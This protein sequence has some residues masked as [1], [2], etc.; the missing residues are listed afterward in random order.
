MTDFNFSSLSCRNK[1]R[2]GSG[3]SLFPFIV[4]L[5]AGAHAQSAG[6]GATAVQIDQNV[7]AI[8]LKYG[9]M[10]EQEMRQEFGFVARERNSGVFVLPPVVVQVNVDSGG[11]VIAIKSLSGPGEISK[12]L[13]SLLQ[14]WS[15]VPFKENG[16]AVCAQFLA[17]LLPPRILPET[18]PEFAGRDKFN[19]TLKRCSALSGSGAQI[20]EVVSACQQAAEEGDPLPSSY[21]GRDKRLA[22]V[23]TATALMRDNRATEA[24]PYAEKAVATADL[25]FDDISGK[26]AAYGVRGQARGLT[27]DLHGADQDL[28]KAEDLERATFE[29]PRKPEQ[30]VFDTH[31]LK[32]MLGFHAEVL[33]AMGKKSDAEK[34]RDEARKL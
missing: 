31:A 27:G 21:F 22:Y 24:L 5:S 18:G 12:L 11:R 14:R 8:H 10:T 32:S 26:A 30:K 3:L 25:G 4:L 29:V 9:H 28:T 7:A 13:V 6:C 1:I 34:L 15:Y 33:T 2:F 23:T 17:K 20:S 19:S 16:Q